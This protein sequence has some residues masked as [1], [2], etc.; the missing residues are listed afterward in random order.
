MLK[1]LVL[2]LLFI[3]QIL[4]NE[5][6]LTIEKSAEGLNQQF[7]VNPQAQII[8]SLDKYD[9]NSG[10]L[11]LKD[12]LLK[13]E[14]NHTLQAKD[15]AIDAARA[16]RD[17]IIGSYLPS[18]DVGYGFSS[19]T[20]KIGGSW[21]RNLNA[22]NL[23]ASANWVLFDGASRE[24]RMASNN[25]LIRAAI[26]DKGYSTE[27]VF[28]Q[29]ASLYY[30]YFSL[31]GQILAMEQKKINIEANLA[32]IQVLYNAGL[33]T[34]EALEALKAELSSTIYQLQ[35]L[36]TS[37]NQIKMQL[38]LFS[39]FEVDK[40][41]LDSVNDPQLRQIQSLNITMQEE[42]AQS[43]EHQINTF[44]YFPSIIFYDNYA[45]N[46]HNNAAKVYGNDPIYS[47]FV[48][49]QFPKHQN[50]F[51]INVVWNIFSGF[52]TNR[53]R[54]SMRLSSLQAHKMIAYAKIEQDNNVKF[55]KQ[56]IDSAKL[57]VQSAKDALDSSIL[58]FKNVEEKYR[59]NLVGYNEYLDSLT[60]RYNAESMYI[61]AL[62]NYELQKANYIFYSG[63]KLL[64]YI[65]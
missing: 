65:N 28:L 33:Q 5:A 21:I 34:L 3:H 57:Q 63:Q 41:K 54:E 58:S 27:A 1:Y 51:G 6:D 35:N 37:F 9:D 30:Q 40:L 49:R 47:S 10:V 42:Q 45:W 31:K 17:S 13:A 18:I 44:S 29:V 26:A 62:N 48:S 25:A 56:S 52:S 20:S 19:T 55:Y 16:N 32:R 36:E 11:G 2:F 23:N 39:N 7:V 43:L 4:A 53:M 64:D 59:A 60:M 22:Q 14:N 12:L 8:D 50:T 46:F 15:L 38:S 24:F 61:N